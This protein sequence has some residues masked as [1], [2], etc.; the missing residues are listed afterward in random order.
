MWDYFTNYILRKKCL[1]ENLIALT[2]SSQSPVM[3]TEH[4]FSMFVRKMNTFDELEIF[5]STLFIFISK[6]R[7]AK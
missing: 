4:S 1:D 2:S 7:L 6:K 5:L 3:Q